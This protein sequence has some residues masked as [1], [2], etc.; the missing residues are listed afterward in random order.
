MSKINWTQVKLHL[1]SARSFDSRLFT[2]SYIIS[3]KGEL[4]CDCPPP[5]S[6]FNIISV[7]LE[8]CQQSRGGIC[9]SARLSA[10]RPSLHSLSPLAVTSN[11]TRTE[12]TGLVM[13]TQFGLNKSSVALSQSTYLAWG[14]WASL[15]HP[16]AGSPVH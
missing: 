1:K 14:G 8:I 7:R 11:Y 9:G 3:L 5:Q 4:S 2:W 12:T 16:A 13:R 15:Q 10:A 6:D